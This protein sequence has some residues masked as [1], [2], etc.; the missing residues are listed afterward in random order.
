MVAIGTH[1]RHREKPRLSHK[2]TEW[3]SLFTQWTFY[4]PYPHRRR[5]SKEEMMAS[6]ERHVHFEDE[7]FPP[8]PTSRRSVRQKR[9]PNHLSDFVCSSVKLRTL[10]RIVYNLWMFINRACTMH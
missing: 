4:S 10:R 2:T 6:D 3:S 1:Y 8:S 5:R 9:F 7:V